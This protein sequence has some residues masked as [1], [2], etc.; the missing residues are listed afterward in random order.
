MLSA[1][2]AS[3]SRLGDFLQQQPFQVGYAQ[4]RK[5]GLEYGHSFIDSFIQQMFIEPLLCA[6]HCFSPSA[7]SC[8]PEIESCPGG[9]YIPAGILNSHLPDSKAQVPWVGRKRWGGERGDH[10]AL[11]L[12]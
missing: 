3:S 8:E 2:C 1:Y 12:L 4:G 5:G 7:Y 11:R 9:S 10:P 6:R